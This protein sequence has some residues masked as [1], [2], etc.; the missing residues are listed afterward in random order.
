MGGGNHAAQRTPALAAGREQRYPAAAERR[1]NTAAE[2]EINTEQRLDPRVRAGP[3]VLERAVQAVAVGQR[4]RFHAK[5]GRAVGQRSRG[6]R[7]VAQRVRGR[8]VQ[9]RKPRGNLKR[10]RHQSA[11]RRS[12]QVRAPASRRS[13]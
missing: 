8:D 9:V 10:Y 2:R 12:V 3:D 11:I 1:V 5:L 4:E 13:S 7:A 6:G